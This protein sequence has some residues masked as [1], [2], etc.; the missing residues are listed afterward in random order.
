M[1]CLCVYMGILPLSGENLA[2]L[3]FFLVKKKSQLG[4]LVH[5]C[6]L[7]SLGFFENVLRSTN[8]RHMHSNIK[9]DFDVTTCRCL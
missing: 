7:W 1:S 5:V 8:L 2:F 4:F 9:I 3:L 6:V